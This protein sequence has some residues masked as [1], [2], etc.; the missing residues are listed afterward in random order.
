M[1]TRAHARTRAHT[2]ALCRERREMTRSGA[3]HTVGLMRHSRT[4]VRSASRAHLRAHAHSRGKT[5]ARATR[6]P[7]SISLFPPVQTCTNSRSRS[8]MPARP[9]CFLPSPLATTSITL[10]SSSLRFSSPLAICSF[11]HH[12][13]VLPTSVQAR[14]QA[15]VRTARIGFGGGGR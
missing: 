8:R 9:R 12:W 1:H 7:G 13:A 10:I 15:S 4:A 2:A 3:A 11:T 6:T 14:V 5:R